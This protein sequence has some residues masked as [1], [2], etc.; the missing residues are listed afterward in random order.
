MI[1]NSGHR[2]RDSRGVHSNDIHGDR[3][4]SFERRSR[5]NLRGNSGNNSGDAFTL[6][7][8]EWTDVA[9]TAMRTHVGDDRHA[10]K[11][12]ANILECSPR[13]AE[14][15]LLGRTAPSGIHFLRAYQA[16]PEFTAEVRRLTHMEASQDPQFERD[17]AEFLVR[18]DKRLAARRIETEGES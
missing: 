3:T 11:R 15:Y 10:V 18:A 14:N 2:A 7:Q 1:Q 12:L 16:I 8:G 4:R 5:G 17:L 9:S 6:T 13:T